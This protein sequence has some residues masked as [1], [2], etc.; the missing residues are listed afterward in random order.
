VNSIL[1]SGWHFLL[2]MIRRENR[3][4][5]ACGRFVAL[6]VSPRRFAHNVSY[7]ERVDCQ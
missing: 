4:G 3:G 6:L 1:K 5:V 2:R 7:K